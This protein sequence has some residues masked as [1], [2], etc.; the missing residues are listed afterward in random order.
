MRAE[1][2]VGHQGDSEG[3]E[4]KRERRG[5][6]V[7]GH[8]EE[9]IEGVRVSMYARTARTPF[10][11]TVVCARALVR[12]HPCATDRIGIRIGSTNGRKLVTAGLPDL[13]AERPPH[14]L[15]FDDPL[16]PLARS[17]ALSTPPLILHAALVLYVYL[18]N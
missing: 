1:R 3:R 17:I 14:P 16:A 12:V 4:R 11:H 13:P 5:Y 2:G 18:T 9:K 6:G 15:T 7:H 10:T 8:R